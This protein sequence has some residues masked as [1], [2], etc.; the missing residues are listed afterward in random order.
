[1]HQLL[2][3]TSY[4]QASTP[5]TF[6]QYKANVNQLS[7]WQYWLFSSNDHATLTLIRMVTSYYCMLTEEYT[8]YSFIY[9]TVS[10]SYR[11]FG[12][13]GSKYTEIYAWHLCSS[14]SVAGNAFHQTLCLVKGQCFTATTSRLSV[15]PVLKNE[16]V[17]I[18]GDVNAHSII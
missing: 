18:T 6:G 14:S 15:Y 9:Y 10:P 17:T 8:G 5:Q 1:M 16:L 13:T 7:S 2:W 4:V 11:R 12:R 3:Y